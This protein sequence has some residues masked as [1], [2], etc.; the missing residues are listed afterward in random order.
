MDSRNWA[1]KLLLALL[2]LQVLSP[3]AVAR[4]D[5]LAEFLFWKA[6]GKAAGNAAM[7]WSEYRAQRELWKQKIAEG[8]A[9]LERCGQCSE[10]AAIEKELAYWQH[11]ENKFHELAGSALASVG[12]PASIAKALDINMPMA[13]FDPEEFRRRH[14]VIRPEWAKDRPQFCQLAVD[15]HVQCLRDYQKRSGVVVTDV[16]KRPGGDCYD[17]RKLFEHCGRKN[18]EGFEMEKRLQAARAAGATIPEYVDHGSF[19][20]VYY[21]PVADDFVPSLPTDVVA[22]KFKEPGAAGEIYLIT[23]KR[24]MDVVGKISIQS[25]FWNTV[26]PSS[27]CFEGQKE[28]TEI[29]RRVCDDLATLSFKE[30]PPILLCQ[31]TEPGLAPANMLQASRFWYGSRPATVDPKR[32]LSRASDHPVLTIGD[33]RTQCPLT[34]REATQL[35]SQWTGKVRQL[36]AGTPQLDAKIVLPES[37]WRQQERDDNKARSESIERQKEATKAFRYDG[38][39][40]FD[41]TL[42]GVAT[43]GRCAISH[44]GPSNTGY[45]FLCRHPKGEVTGHATPPFSGYLQVSW[46]V[47]KKLVGLNYLADRSDPNVLVGTNPHDKATTGRLVR[48]HDLIPLSDLPIKGIYS[49]ERSAKGVTESGECRISTYDKWRPPP[50]TFQCTTSSGGSFSN[51]AQPSRENAIFVSWPSLG[52]LGM[53]GLA[54]IVDAGF[55][56]SPKTPLALVGWNREGASVRLVRTGDLPPEQRQS[57]PIA[58]A[59]AGP[60]AGGSRTGGRPAE[61]AATPQRA[62]SPP[63][64]RAPADSGAPRTRCALENLTGTYRTAFGSLVCK[65]AADGG[66]ECC[67]GSRCANTA[68]LAFD[69]SG[70]NMVGTWRYPNGTSGPVTFPISPQCDLQSGRWGNAGR[71]PERSWAVRGR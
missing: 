31:Y 33:P 65:E 57:P 22:A 62:P 43:A 71:T 5:A 34:R 52:G 4:A 47:G 2:L 25:F 42:D 11:T 16:A 50:F 8:K 69:E 36:R 35:E 9:K 58:S 63:A 54:F 45:L 24:G 29:E 44:S 61:V 26:V 17:T 6:M 70:Q 14:E 18:Y 37:E 23:R 38:V 19:L 20:E 48:L 53:H 32:L 51:T 21:G 60:G 28:R 3:T 46:Y 56:T 12:M 66:L 55:E 40:S 30:R 27:K 15:T 39:Y 64:S 7:H 13:P 1:I 67:Y 49:F 10:R 68:K 41:M 59:E